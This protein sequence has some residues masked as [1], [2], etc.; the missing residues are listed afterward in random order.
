MKRTSKSPR[1]FVYATLLVA[2][3]FE[4]GCAGIE[5]ATE[6]QNESNNHEPS[7]QDSDTGVEETSGTE[8]EATIYKSVV[9]NDERELIRGYDP[10][11]YTENIHSNYK[12]VTPPDSDLVKSLKLAVGALMEPID[13]VNIR[14]DIND[15]DPRELSVNCSGTL[16]SENLFLTAGHCC[17][18]NGK[19]HFTD[20]DPDMVGYILR[21]CNKEEMK[22]QFVAFNYELDEKPEGGLYTFDEIE[23]KPNEIEKYL[24]GERY[25]IKKIVENVRIEARPFE[26]LDVDYMILELEENSEGTLPGEKYGYTPL[27]LTSPQKTEED[28][29]S[30][31]GN[32]ISTEEMDTFPQDL[33]LGIIHHSSYLG[34]KGGGPKQVSVGKV[35][36]VQYTKYGYEFDENKNLKVIDAK[37][38]ELI[39]LEHSAD[40]EHCASG[41]GMID[42]VNG[43]LIGVHTSGQN[44][45]E[46]NKG[47]SI[48]YLIKYSPALNALVNKSDYTEM[49]FNRELSDLNDIDQCIGKPKNLCYEDDIFLFDSCGRIQNEIEVCTGDQRC[50]NG[51]DENVTACYS[52]SDEVDME[53]IQKEFFAEEGNEHI[54]YSGSF[55]IGKKEK[56]T[57]AYLYFDFYPEMSIYE[58]SIVLYCPTNGKSQPIEIKD[59]SSYIPHIKDSHYITECNGDT[60]DKEFKLVLRYDKSDGVLS[61]NWKENSWEP[62]FNKI[63]L[64]VETAPEEEDSLSN[65]PLYSEGDDDVSN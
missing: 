55:K 5:S 26:L 50:I 32:Q 61:T 9:N 52:S 13:G 7:T 47:M 27:T 12:D 59:K 16:I 46:W 56:I 58:L 42:A 10:D 57:N 48:E 22:N 17:P 41:S 29:Q 38:N 62:T 39:K 21:E 1:G 18:S 36:E 20:D 64:K 15:Y 24:I 11:S 14:E 2:L 23:D 3:L 6:G 60:A 4:Y 8:L 30:G 37:T 28:T 31:D 25:K 35:T 63:S 49:S 34:S 54:T 40:T 51:Q 33:S 65:G 43:K 19:F 53:D 44:G 45:E